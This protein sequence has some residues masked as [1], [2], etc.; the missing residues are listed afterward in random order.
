MSLPLTSKLL[1]FGH[2]PSLT[3][4]LGWLCQYKC[5]NKLILIPKHIGLRTKPGQLKGTIRELAERHSENED[6]PKIKTTLEIRVTQKS[7]Q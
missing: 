4:Y 2:K 1:W 7:R 5:Q 3:Y 6:D